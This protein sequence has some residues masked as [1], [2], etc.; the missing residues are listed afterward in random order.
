MRIKAPPVAAELSWA[1]VHSF[2]LARHHLL[3]RAPKAR[4]TQVVGDIGGA[5]AQ[6]M[7]TAELQIAVRVDCTVEDV[8]EA[9]WKKKSLVKNAWLKYLQVNEAQLTKLFDSID[10]A[11]NGSPMTREELIAAV[12]RDQP[13]PVLRILRSGWGGVLKPAARRGQLCF[14]PNRGQSVTF[15]RPQA[16]LGTWKEMDPEKATVA[17]AERYLS[18]YGPATKQDFTRWWGAWLG[19]GTAAWKA[20]DEKVVT[21]SVEGQKVQMLGE[22]LKLLRKNSQRPSVQLLPGFDP[23]LMGHATRDHLFDKI[24]RWKVSRVAGWISPV[25]LVDGRV[26]GVWSHTVAKQKV[27][28]ELKPFASLPARVVKAAGERAE[29]IAGA[30]GAKLE[31]FSVA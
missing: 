5:Q 28:V 6:V 30:L 3:E 13:E 27:R 23:Y 7:S 15:V 1:D 19:V 4:L 16:W 21:V 17:A 26:L 11:L 2:R 8:R 25:V 20:L 18:A 12:G 14:G 24:H 9:L 31:K 10:G 29:T 22:D